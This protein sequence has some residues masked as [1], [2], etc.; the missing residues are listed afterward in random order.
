MIIWLLGLEGDS[1]DFGLGNI[2]VAEATP[3]KR[4]LGLSDCILSTVIYALHNKM[5]HLHVEIEEGITFILSCR[6]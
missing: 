4:G 1:G 5:K 3:S 6:K 2:G